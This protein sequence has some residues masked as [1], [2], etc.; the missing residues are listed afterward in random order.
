MNVEIKLL[1]TRNQDRKPQIQDLSS[2][3]AIRKIYKIGESKFEIK[4]KE[5]IEMVNLDNR[6]VPSEEERIKVTK[7]EA[8]ANKSTI[9]T[10]K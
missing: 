10:Y 2:F 6:Q 3:H 9:V 5:S 4:T 1:R 7:F 8:K